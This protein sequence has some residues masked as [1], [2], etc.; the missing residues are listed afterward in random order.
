MVIDYKPTSGGTAVVETIG[1]GS[2]HEMITVIHPDG[3]GLSLTH[4]C[5][6]GNQPQMRAAKS[7]ISGKSIAFQFVRATNMKS[8][9][10]AHMHSVTYT[11]VDKDTLKS[12]WTN[13][14]DGKPGGKMAFLL[15]RKK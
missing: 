7:D 2:E 9:K 6:L 3:D 8:E 10:D 15:T 14:S 13:Y 4:Y 5:M 1:A 11:F 12:E